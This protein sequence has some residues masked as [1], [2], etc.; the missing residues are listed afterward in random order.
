MQSTEIV[1]SGGELINEFGKVNVRISKSRAC[2]EKANRSKS[3]TDVI[4][5]TS[6]I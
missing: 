1:D 6:V 5:S 3:T 4:T 2:V